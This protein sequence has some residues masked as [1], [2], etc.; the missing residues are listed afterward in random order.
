M[1]EGPQ[2]SQWQRFG[3][4]R[5]MLWTGVAACGAVSL[6]LVVTRVEVVQ[7][8][9]AD[10]PA[11]CLLVVALIVGIALGKTDAS[12][13]LVEFVIKP[14]SLVL[15]SLTAFVLLAVGTVLVFG[16]TPLSSDEHVHLF[17]A[18]LF[19]QFKVVG[20]YPPALVDQIIPPGYLH[21]TIL[22]STDGRAMA[23]TW[24]GWA[25]LMTP[26]V[27]LGAPWLLGPAMASVGIYVLGRLASLLSG[28]K[29]AAIAILLTATSGAFIVTGMSVYP[30]G[31]H[32]TLSLLYAWL[33]VR[34]GRRD[35][36]LAGLVGG[37][38]LNLN[39][40]V[41]HA[42]FALPWLIWLAADRTRRG[43]LVWLAAGYVP[44]LIVFFGWFAEAS[45]I[46][47]FQQGSV[48][49]A[50]NVPTLDAFSWRLWELVR[51][52]AWAAPGLL[53]LAA[54]GWRRESRK[55]A[56]WI[57]GISFA[58]V[59]VLYTLF[60]QSQGLGWG[61]RY[62]QTAWG[63][64]PILAA[65]LL[66]RPGQEVLTRTVVVAA[67]AGLVLVV[68]LQVVYAHDL[69]QLGQTSSASIQALAAP[70]VN[71]YFVRFDDLEDSSIT[72]LDDPSLS[73]TVILASRGADADRQVVDR[74][75]PGA[76]LVTSNSH[77]S[78]YTRP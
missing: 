17:Q 51:V 75:F 59:V 58:V 63:V 67:L 23:T 27:W 19:A 73:G 62:Y 55:S 12:R 54:I 32:L 65:L 4:P 40:P 47:A 42:L 37:L 38:A 64:L 66:V 52:W 48:S 68:P 5:A 31:G 25:L 10:L 39:N 77:G 29:A 2:L 22:V 50:V 76:R 74:W 1:T 3:I 33:L 41:P 7:G 53:L 21:N 45:S 30:S 16:T 28:A 8:Q 18:R 9:I 26:F 71:L 60:P 49:S 6:L 15:V 43:R 14:R 34:G 69:A 61:A 20:S 24:P 13:R 56:A 36:V 44:W 78:G 35:T 57:L 11:M 70:G 72:L 46:Q